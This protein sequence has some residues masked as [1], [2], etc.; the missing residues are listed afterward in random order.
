MIEYTTVISDNV[1]FDILD[2]LV[3]VRHYLFAKRLKFVTKFKGG[4]DSVG[5]SGVKYVGGTKLQHVVDCG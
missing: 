2:W 5:R 4:I 3:R 1:T